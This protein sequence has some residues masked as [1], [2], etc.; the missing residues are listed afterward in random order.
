MSKFTLVRLREVVGKIS[1][2]KLVEDDYC[3][4]DEFMKEIESEGNLNKHLLS[5]LA[6]MDQVA[7]LKLLPKSKY[8]DITPFRELIKE[9]EIKKGDLRVYLIKEEE[10]ILILGGKKNS[11]AKDIRKFRSIKERYLASKRNQQL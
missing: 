3:P 8:K 4:F 1:F 5:I 7:N 10:H 6:I 2:S 9:F 11:Q